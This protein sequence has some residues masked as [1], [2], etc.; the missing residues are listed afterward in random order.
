MIVS[1]GVDEVLIKVLYSTADKLPS[2]SMENRKTKFRNKRDVFISDNGFSKELR[3]WKSD[4][5]GTNFI[6]E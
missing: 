1:D 5:M 2:P 4:G 3:D 6:M